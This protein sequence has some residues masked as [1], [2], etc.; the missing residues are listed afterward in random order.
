MEVA[1]LL[2]LLGLGG[3]VG[4]LLYLHLVPTGLSPIQNPVSPYGITP[5]RGG[6]RAATLAFALGA[7]S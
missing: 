7:P 5:Y 2:A 3:T 4:S 6:Y 1:A